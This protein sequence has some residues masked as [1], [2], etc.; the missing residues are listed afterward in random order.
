MMMAKTLMAFTMVAALTVAACTA[1]SPSTSQKQPSA[2]KDVVA[3]QEKPQKEDK[4]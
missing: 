2:S 1:Q 4:E 3:P